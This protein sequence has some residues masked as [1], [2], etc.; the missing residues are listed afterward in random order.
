MERQ[1]RSRDRPQVD[2]QG[3]AFG[4]AGQVLRGVADC[5]ECLLEDA[6]MAGLDQET[7]LV[8]A[9][10]QVFAHL[11]LPGQFLQQRG[12]L[13]RQSERGVTV[14]GRRAGPLQFDPSVA[15]DQLA[16]VGRE[17]RR[18]GE[19]AEP[20]KYINHRIGRHAGRGGVPQRQGGQAVGVNVFRTF[21]QLGEGRQ[22]VA[23]LG[24][25]RVVY[26]DENRAIAL[27]DEG[28]GR[29]VIHSL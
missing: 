17:V 9:L 3:G 21:L 18:Q 22:R 12:V 13:A 1:T 24:V 25:A 15:T 28:I 26:L 4:V 5:D 11:R 2:G 6:T 14:L 16:D 7:L 19:F 29:I 10:A 27:D 20:S 8:E 23:R